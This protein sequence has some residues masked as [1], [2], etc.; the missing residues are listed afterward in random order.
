M[1]YPYKTV[2]VVDGVVVSQAVMYQAGGFPSGPPDSTAYDLRADDQTTIGWRC[3][4]D[5]AY[6]PPQVN[7]RPP[8]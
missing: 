1:E 8:A 2:Y 6:T 3:I 5:D 7:W 4:I